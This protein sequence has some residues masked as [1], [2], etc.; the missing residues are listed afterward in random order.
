[1]NFYT[2]R[3]CFIDHLF[4]TSDFRQVPCH[5][6][7]EHPERSSLLRRNPVL[8]IG[9]QF[10]STLVTAWAQCMRYRWGQRSTANSSSRFCLSGTFQS[11]L[12]RIQIF[13]TSISCHSRPQCL[14]LECVGPDQAPPR[15]DCVL[16]SFADKVAAC[17]R[18]L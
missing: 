3:P 15:A 9:M 16:R 13:P 12:H 4:L 8:M 1:M 18:R 11:C 10:S 5:N 17:G 6:V 14:G 2:L 7:H